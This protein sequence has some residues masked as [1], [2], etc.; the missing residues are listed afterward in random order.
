MQKSE[1]TN[2]PW[3]G[4]NLDIRSPLLQ[5]LHVVNCREGEE[6]LSDEECKEKIAA[7]LRIVGRN[8]ER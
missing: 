6:G 1:S 5:N 4:V 7:C 8:G 2:C 3:C